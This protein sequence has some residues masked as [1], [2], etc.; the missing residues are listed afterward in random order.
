MRPALLKTVLL[1]LLV[2]VTQPQAMAGSFNTESAAPEVRQT[3]LKIYKYSNG[4]TTSFSDRPPADGRYTVLMP[5]CFACNLQSNVN[6]QTTALYA[7]RFAGLI[8]Q[9]ARQFQLDPALVRAV[10]HAESGFNPA[11]RSSKGAMGLMQLMPGTARQMGVADAWMPEQ[12]IAGGV[13]YLAGLLQQFRGDQKLA[14]AAYNAGPEA[15]RKYAGI[16]PYAETQ[17]YVQ[18]VQILQQRYRQGAAG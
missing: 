17:A 16:P 8:E 5:T 14:V 2:A 12:N 6:W 1:F 9:T 4:G 7:Q 13:Q 11:A 10:I 18:R 3:P 15:V